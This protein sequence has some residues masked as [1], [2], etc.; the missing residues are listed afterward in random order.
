MNKKGQGLVEALIALGAAVI[1]ISAITIAVIMAVSNS[2]FSKDQNLAT[3]YAQQGIQVIQQKSQL[4]WETLQASASAAVWCLPQGAT[5][6]YPASLGPS[7]CDVNISGGFVRQVN[8]TKNSSNCN[9]T[10]T[11][12]E[13]TVAWTD[14]KCSADTSSSNYYCHQVKLDT[15]VAD[16]NRTQ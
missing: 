13:V 10:G 11:Q 16:I 3:G 6:F 1:I 2:D 4:D 7:P 14:G 8:F 15:C 9:N 5:D 12:V